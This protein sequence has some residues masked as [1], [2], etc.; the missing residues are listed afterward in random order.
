MCASCGAGGLVCF[1]VF[2]VLSAVRGHGHPSGVTAIDT[3]QNLAL[4]ARYWKVS[5]VDLSKKKACVSL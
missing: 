3:F 1:M 5:P 4:G 2:V